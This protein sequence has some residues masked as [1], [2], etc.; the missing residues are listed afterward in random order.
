MRHANP[1]RGPRISVRAFLVAALLALGAAAAGAD[2]AAAP[3]ARPPELASTFATLQTYCLNGDVSVAALVARA[4]ADGWLPVPRFMI[5]PLP[6]S[7][8]LKD[9][10]FKLKTSDA[11]MRILIGGAGTF[12]KSGQSFDVTLCGVARAPVD[13]DLLGDMVRWTGVSAMSQGAQPMFVFRERDGGR[14]P[15]TIEDVRAGRPVM[16]AMVGKSGQ[17]AG[18]QSIALVLKIRSRQDA[19]LDPRHGSRRPG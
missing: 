3:A 9:V 17:G 1:G 14:V 16:I 10:G 18:Q 13:E 6:Q 2:Q 19:A 11:D 8:S 7:L 4:E 12:A 5:P 15:A